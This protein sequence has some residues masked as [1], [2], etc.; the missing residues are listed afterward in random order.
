MSLHFSAQ[1]FEDRFRGRRLSNWEYP[2]FAPPR[3]RTIRA[4]VKILAG[5]DGHLLPGVRREGNSF[6]H[7]RGTYELPLKITRKFCEHY[8]ACLS[9]RYKFRDYPRDLCSCQWENQ[10]ALACDKRRT[11]G[12]KGDPRWER[13]Q[14]QT[15]C[16][17]LHQLTQLY[18]RSQRCKRARCKDEIERT[19]PVP[20]KAKVAQ[21]STDQRRRRKRTI[22][23]FPKPRAT[24]YANESVASYD[25]RTHKSDKD[26]I[27]AVVAPASGKSK[28]KEKGRSKDSKSSTRSDKD[29]T[30]T[31]KKSSK[32]RHT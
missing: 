26:K 30:K 16:E 32:T 6:G 11:L 28:E 15:K 5:Q 2:R 17:G 10:R 23:A 7:Y 3:P 29:K 1:Q 25:Q 13:Q 4:K 24:L 21:V 20:L 8:D 9:G 12:E 18:N 22:T 14:C 31:T 19:V 27:P